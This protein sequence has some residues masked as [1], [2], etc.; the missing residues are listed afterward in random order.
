MWAEG[1]QGGDLSTWL[2]SLSGR[3]APPL[4]DLQKQAVFVF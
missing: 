4:N 3:L 1:V 2:S